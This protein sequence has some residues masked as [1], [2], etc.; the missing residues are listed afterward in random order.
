MSE[1]SDVSI[2]AT[3]IVQRGDWRERQKEEAAGSGGSSYS[4]R[5]WRL[6]PHTSLFPALIC[7]IME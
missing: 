2:S 1:D 5:G 7:C 4:R 3:V 6:H